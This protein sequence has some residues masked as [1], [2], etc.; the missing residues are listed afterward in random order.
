MDRGVLIGGII[1]GLLLAMPVILPIVGANYL[2][3]LLIKAMLLAIAALSLDLIIG[4]GGMVSLGHAAFI[5]IGAYA[6]AISLENGIEE[7]LLLFLI[8]LGATASIALVT[9]VLA[10]RTSGVYFLMI[11]LA[12]G[13]MTFFTLTSLAAYGGDDGLTLWSLAT[14]FGSDIVQEG[15][16]L[17]F[18]VLVILIF[19]WIGVWR[20]SRSRFGRVLKAARDNPKRAEVMGY[21]IARYQLI[22]YVIAACIAGISGLLLVQYA[23]FV[24]PSISAWQRSGDLIVAIVLGGLGSRN[25]AILGAFFIVIMEEFLSS[26][27]HE[28]RLIYGPL[29]VL[30]VL[31]AKGGLSDLILPKSSGG[32]A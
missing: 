3:G 26:I 18:F 1:F 8:A 12:F 4:H 13:Q 16:G 9:G 2:S 23:E 20:I 17:Y 22:A 31:Y 32:G 7:I 25:G 5:G 27:F 19:T 30:L 24:S 29:L 14:L 28:W 10:L 15:E 11:T 21:P 6:T